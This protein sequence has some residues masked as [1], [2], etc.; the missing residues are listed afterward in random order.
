[1]VSGLK[2][3]SMGTGT[4]PYVREAR[5]AI[6]HC[7]ELRPHSAILSPFL[8]PAVS[9][10][11][12]SFAILRAIVRYWNETPLKSVKASSSQFSRMACS[13][14]LIMDCSINFCLFSLL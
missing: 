2:S 11:M 13:M 10:A 9:Y 5:N 8:I 7:A 3:W 4:A 1:M 6:D 14:Y 12:C